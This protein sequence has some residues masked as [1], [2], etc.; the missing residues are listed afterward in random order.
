MR[1]TFFITSAILYGFWFALFLGPIII[2][3]I[4][5]SAWSGADF[6]SFHP[7][8]GWSVID[9]YGV[10]NIFNAFYHNVSNHI[11]SDL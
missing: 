4:P 3:S 1:K 6:S 2:L 10:G 8:N 11:G 9:H 7:N 5:S